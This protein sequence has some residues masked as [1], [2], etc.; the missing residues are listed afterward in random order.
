MTE[1]ISG[2]GSGTVLTA[3]TFTALI[4]VCVCVCAKAIPRFSAEHLIV[5]HSAWVPLAYDFYSV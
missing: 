1:S 4:N 3:A 5:V 2:H